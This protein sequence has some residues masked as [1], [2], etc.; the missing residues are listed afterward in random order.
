MHITNIWHPGLRIIEFGTAEGALGDALVRAGYQHYLAVVGN[1]RLSEKIG[2]THLRLQARLALSGP[3]AVRKN[4]AEVLILGGRTALHAIRFRSIRHAHYVALPLRFS[5][6]LP[7]ALLAGLVHCLFGRLSRPTIV[8]VNRDDGPALRLITFGVRRRHVPPV[9]RYIPHALGIERF[10]RRLN[11]Q[12]VGY[13]ALRWFEALPMLPPGEDLDLLIQDDDLPTLAALLDEGPGLQPID[14]YSVTGLPGADYRA[15][16]YFPPHVSQQILERARPRHNLCW[17]PSSEDHFLSLAYHALYHKGFR[18]AIPSRIHNWPSRLRPEHDYA[19]ILGKL[20]RRLGIDVPIELE[21]LDALLDERGWRPPHD[22]LV[23]LARHNNWLK[24][25][26]QRAGSEAGDTGLAVF[27]LRQEALARGGIDRA[28][29]LIERHG[30]SVLRTAAIEG[31]RAR[32]VTRLIRGGNWGRGPWPISG[33]P[34]AAVIVAYDMDPVKPSRR[35]KRK[36]PFLA[37]ARLLCKDKIRD[38]FNQDRPPAEHCNTI[39]S[40]DNG[41]EASDY[42]RAIL[43]EAVD[44]ILADVERLRAGYRTD[45][46]VVAIRTRAGR[47]AKIEVVRRD[48]RLVVKKTFKPHQE[49]FCQREA[50]ALC[51]LSARVPEVPPVLEREPSSLTIPYY[52]NVLDYERSSGKLLPLD[53]AKQ[54]VAALDKVY[55]AGYAIVDASIDNILVD[56][57]EGLKLI[58]F[59]FAHRYE[60]KPA[61][62]EQSYDVAGCPAD[63]SGDQPIQGGNSYRRNWQPYIGLSLDA[64]RSD[65]AWLQHLK[66]TLYVVAHGHRFLPRRV[67]HY[68]RMLAAHLRGGAADAQPSPLP[69]EVAPADDPPQ[70]ER[71]RAA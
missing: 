42:L 9:R 13:V 55:D 39:H 56:R 40:S 16:P 34:P 25:L 43:P 63:F 35:Q 50:A 52:D 31:D 27:V 37:N 20:A 2:E 45:E 19:S 8:H 24:S 18:S 57:H 49:R 17:V 23:R 46:P 60:Q 30:F 21:A 10:L 33:G 68:Y 32:S 62:F 48:G 14:L 36:F 22:M 28:T 67:R 44:D 69:S 38:A 29:Q 64:L 58:D 51:E 54:A 6:T 4:N 47:R 61:T 15:M 70:P 5:V 66:R 59:E 11:R 53:V 26:L 71:R 12:R 41:R 3:S 7:L 1:K 65:P